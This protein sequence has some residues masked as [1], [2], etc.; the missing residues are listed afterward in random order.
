MEEIKERMPS[1]QKLLV[2]LCF[3]Y[4][5]ISYVGRY[6]YS[7]NINPI[8]AD[9]KISKATAGLTP[10]FFFFAYG[11]GQIV[12]GIM[13]KKYPRK[14]VLPICMFLSASI[15]FS[16]FLGIPFVLV[17]Y[18]WLLNGFILATLWPSIILTISKNVEKRHLQKAIL[19]MSASCAV[20]TFIAYG[21]SAIFVALGRYKLIFIFSA[22]LML[23]M[24]IAWFFSF[25]SLTTEQKQETATMGKSTLQK[26]NK[27][28]DPSVFAIIS[29]LAFMAVSVNIVRD[30]LHTWV[31]TILK[32]SYS[33]KDSLSILLSI[34]L[35]V[36][37]VFSATVSML[38]RK[39][40]S[41]FVL[42]AGSLFA[43]SA[44]L[45][46]GCLLVLDISV[47]IPLLLLFCLLL[48]ST[49][50]INNIITSVTP[51]YMRDK[52]NS[53]LVAGVLN[54]FCYIGSTISSYGLGAIADKW[55]WNAVFYLFIG[56]CVFSASVSLVY[57]IL[58][59]KKKL[60]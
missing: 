50:A 1:K 10:S 55:D 59:K 51:L 17:K 22:I 2:L 37:G 36:F 43:F 45:V 56:V 26:E 19:V 18:L 48:V 24:A 9:Y 15:N 12:H 23:T 42:A 14:Y 25:D 54:G 35:P 53:G 21:F 52:V 27:K 44:V 11:V 33:L 6:T 16:I 34:V 39:K 47:C 20:G 3:L 7:A 58:T 8:M 31:P 13:C 29:S 4:Y 57:A 28:F 41:N 40:I 30:G 60:G 46:L 49:G 5:T 32:D 38:V